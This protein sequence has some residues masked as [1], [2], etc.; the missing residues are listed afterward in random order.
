MDNN[1]PFLNSSTDSEYLNVLEGRT[2][3]K[4]TRDLAKK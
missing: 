1:L 4:M 2:W 3:D